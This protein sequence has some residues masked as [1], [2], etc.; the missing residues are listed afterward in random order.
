MFPDF[1]ELGTVEHQ[2]DASGW[3]IG[4]C[5]HRP[6]SERDIEKIKSTRGHGRGR[7]QNFFPIVRVEV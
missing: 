4:V 7:G 3:E 5:F 2:I 1:V 6:Q